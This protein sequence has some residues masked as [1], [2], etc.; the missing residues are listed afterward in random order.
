MAN[1]TQVKGHR[2]V[3]KAILIVVVSFVIGHYLYS[4]SMREYEQNQGLTPNEYVEDFY[5]YKEHQDESVEPPP[6]AL[7]SYIL[8]T[9]VLLSLFVALYELAGMGIGWSVRR[10][11]DSAA[12]ESHEQGREEMNTLGNI[13]QRLQARV[14]R[15]LGPME[16]IRWIEQP[17]PRYFTT[18]A[19]GFFFFGIPWT[20]FA[21]FWTCGAAGFELPDFSEGIKGVELFPLFGIPFILIG[22]GMLT[23]PLWAYRSAFK[24]V[25]VI[26]DLRAI[27]FD[28]GRSTVIRSYPPEKLQDVY[29][30][31][32]R[33]GTGDVIISTRTW[34]D[35]DDQQHSEELGFL[36]IG[37]PKTV[38]HML[39]DLAEQRPG[40][41]R[42]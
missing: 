15:E 14:N 7:W 30:K 42:Q 19:K 2:G 13:P 18:K 32:N 28:G 41:G 1:I 20:A 33:D 4:N 21:I 11:R 27:T 40:A 24:T 35:S 23:S 31:E 34:R 6:G 39:K 36:R 37:D 10:I 9:L 38:E 3:A 25:Y 8:F 29:R 16:V 12:G 26:T 5:E 22:L 17:I